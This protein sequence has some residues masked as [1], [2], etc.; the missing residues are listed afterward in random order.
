MTQV[1]M[2]HH[3]QQTAEVFDGAISRLESS[4]RELTR[5]KENMVNRNDLSYVS[6]AINEIA[7][8]PQ[9]CR[10]DLFAT[11]PLRAFGV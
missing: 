9:A 11:R 8:I 5:L 2:T 1:N 7:N 10:L 3:I 6:E 4:I